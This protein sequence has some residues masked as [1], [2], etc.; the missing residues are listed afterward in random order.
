MPTEREDFERDRKLFVGGL[1]YETSDAVLKEYFEQY[2]ELT[3]W[4]V[5]KFPDTKRSRGFGFIT[6]KEPEMLEDCLSQQPHSLDG[7]TVELK[8]ATPRDEDRRGGRGGGG[9]RG[10]R[11]GRGDEEE[12][13]PESKQMRKLFIGGL[14][15]STTE[16]EIRDYFQQFGELV[17]CVLMK[18]NDSGRSRGFGFVTYATAAMLDN[19]QESR[20]H[21]L[22]D[23]TL[24]TKRATPR[25]DSAK[26][27][28]QMC[29]KKLFVGGVSDEMEDEDIRDYFSQYGKVINV[30]Q[31]RWNESGKKR[32][33]GFVEFEDYDPVDKVCL[34][35]KHLLKGRRL[36]VKKALSKQEMSIMKKN[37]GPEDVWGDGRGNR[38]GGGGRNM[39]RD[40][41]RDDRDSR[42]RGGRNMGGGGGGMGMS[43]MM[44]DMMTQMN[45]RL[46][47][48]SN[49][50]QNMN[51][52]SGMSGMGG[53]NNMMSQMSGAMRG[54]GSM[55]GF[56]GG[57]SSDMGN[58]MNQMGGGMMNPGASSS[59]GMM[60][61]MGGGMRGSNMGGGGFQGGFG[62]DMGGGGGGFDR[63]SSA[64]SGMM[65]GEKGYST[66]MRGM[67]GGRSGGP[68]RG[69]GGNQSG[70][71]STAP[72]TRRSMDRGSMGGR[73]F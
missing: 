2:G 30:E 34:V 38:G 44:N 19:C 5:M 27:E 51:Q 70:R 35:G 45:M 23:K 66:G 22:G 18:F 59:S 6:F 41:W 61:M 33:F 54:G 58:M 16:E 49:F 25:S 9:G 3:D 29:V 72:Y 55:G 21:V 47:Q 73:R 11:G 10:G 24:E 7:K 15:Y 53:M 68:M 40:D 8:R 62:N 56:N 63:F 69:P 36:E 39:R 13:D 42:D 57:F 64:D 52:M 4:V 28:S 60:D 46:N 37:T 26:P 32:G 14:N 71:D 1:D 12:F 67:G 17:D 43:N 50:N 48:M 65:G 20:P 31:L